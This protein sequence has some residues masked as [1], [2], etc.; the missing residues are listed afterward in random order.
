MG[1]EGGS[2]GGGGG[3]RGGG[4]GGEGGKG[5][6]GEGRRGEWRDD[7]GWPKFYLSLLEMHSFTFRCFT[8]LYSILS[9]NSLSSIITFAPKEISSLFCL[10]IAAPTSPPLPLPPFRWFARKPPSSIPFPIVGHV[11]EAPS[12]SSVFGVSKLLETFRKLSRRQKL[13]GN[14]P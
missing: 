7:G 4:C 6:G 2:F 9:S 14:F 1:G 11:G 12:N 8:L 5:M 10:L 13:S 3:G